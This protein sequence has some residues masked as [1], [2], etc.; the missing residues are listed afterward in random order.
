MKECEAVSCYALFWTKGAMFALLLNPETSVGRDVR[1]KFV[2][3]EGGNLISS[4]I[5]RWRF[6]RERLRIFKGDALGIFE[7]SMRSATPFPMSNCDSQIDLLLLTLDLNLADVLWCL[8]RCLSGSLLTCKVRRIA[9]HA[10]PKYCNPLPR[11]LRVWRL[12]AVALTGTCM[13]GMT[14][15]CASTRYSD[16][17]SVTF[18]SASPLLFITPPGFELG[19]CSYHLS[20]SSP[21]G[22]FKMVSAADIVSTTNPSYQHSSDTFLPDHVH[23]CTLGGSRCLATTVEHDDGH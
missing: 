15:A 8:G 22:H 2:F 23:R 11:M 21:R 1:G 9:K 12:E 18:L 3:S 4:I 13:S 14:Q 20:A 17:P 5:K 6:W 10:G 7:V 19:Y 16:L